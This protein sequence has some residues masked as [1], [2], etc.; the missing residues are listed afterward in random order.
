MKTE[1]GALLLSAG[2]ALTVGIVGL[3]FSL[4][5]GSQAILLDGLFNLSYFVTALLTLRVARL[6]TRPDDEDFPLG[7]SYFE[8]LMNGVKGILILGISAMALFDAVNSLLTGGRQIGI[9]L[10]IGYGVFATIAC[11]G[12]GILLRRAHRITGSPLVGVDAESWTVNGAISGAVLLTFCAVP[13]V[14]AMGWTEAVPYVDPFLVTVVVLISVSIP[15]RMAWQAL[16]ELLNRAPPPEVRG[17]IAALVRKELGELPSRKVYVRM[18]RPGRTLYVAV[19]V[20]LSGD[21]PVSDLGTLDAIRDRVDQAVRRIH[22]NVFVEVVFTADERWAAP[23]SA[24]AEWAAPSPP[25]AEAG[26]AKEG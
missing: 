8:P 13:I 17:P 22:P 3:A 14:A 7:Y 24:V 9:G 18:I 4:L 1:R 26:A 5:T 2:S 10:A 11:S 19:H 6:V 23:S 25:D 12:T 16:M 15:V 21:F 20:L